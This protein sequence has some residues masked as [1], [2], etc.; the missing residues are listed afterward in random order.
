MSCNSFFELFASIATKWVPNSEKPVRDG[1]MNRYDAY[2]LDW[3]RITAA[4]VK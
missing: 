4:R 2:R 1:R 3:T